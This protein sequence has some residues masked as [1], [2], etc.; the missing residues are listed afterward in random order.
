MAPFAGHDLPLVDVLDRIV[1]REDRAVAV[2]IGQE[3]L[4]GLAGREQV[5]ASA[6]DCAPLR[7]PLFPVLFSRPR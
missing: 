1:P 7:I 4:L 6:M 3:S 2:R 5:G